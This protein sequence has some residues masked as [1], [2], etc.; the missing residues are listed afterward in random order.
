VI[1]RE[2]RHRAWDELARKV[3]FGAYMESLG[4]PM[5]MDGWHAHHILFKEGLR[6]AQQALVV[7]GQELLWEAGI[8]PI[9][10]PEN[11][12][13]APLRVKDQHSIKTLQRTVEVSE[14]FGPLTGGNKP[15]CIQ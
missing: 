10:G 11:L 6:A 12:V 2:T 7:E 14:I 15:R 9:V 1:D 3:D 4:L 13:W 8:H 5:P